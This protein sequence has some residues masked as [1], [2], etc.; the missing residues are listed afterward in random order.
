MRRERGGARGERG[1]GGFAG[2]GGAAGGTCRA[3]LGGRRGSG[4]LSGGSEA[5]LEWTGR[6]GVPPVEG[7][8]PWAHAGALCEDGGG[9][10]E[11]PD[12]RARL[13]S[14]VDHAVVHGEGLLAISRPCAGVGS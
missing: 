7:V 8:L 5:W 11:P 9:W 3:A 12:G 4:T 13:L 14:L 10:R 1:G 6:L 2:C